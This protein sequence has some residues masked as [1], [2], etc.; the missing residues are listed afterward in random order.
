MAYLHASWSASFHVALAPRTLHTSAIA[1][2]D[3]HVEMSA[4]LNALV[5]G[6]SIGG[7]STAHALL[8]AG[9]GVTVL[10]RAPEVSGN[11]LGAGLGLDEPVCDLLRSWTSKEQFDKN[12]LPLPIEVNRVIENRKAKTLT[13]DDSYKHRATHWSNIHHTLLNALPDKNIIQFH[14]T[15]TDFDQPEGSNKVKVTA[16]V[17]E[18][19][20]PK[21]FEGDFLVACDGSMS[22]V[23]AKFR[24]HD[25]RRY[26][27][28][29]AWRGVMRAGENP[30]VA[31]SVRKAYSMG[32]TLYFDIAKGTHSVLYELPEERL[33]WLWYVNQPEPELKGPSVTIKATEDRIQQMHREAEQIWPPELAQLMKA[34]E[35]PFINA[36]FDKE[37]LDQ[38]VWGRV[39]LLGEA[40]HPTTP[41]G[42]RSTNMAIGDAGKLGS[43]IKKHRGDL[44][45]A[46]QE[47][48]Q[49]RMAQTAKEVLFSRWLGQKKQGLSNPDDPF[50]WPHADK[51]MLD[52]LRQSNMQSF[53]AS[54]HDFATTNDNSTTFPD[55]ASSQVA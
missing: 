12:S 36:I 15:V 29:V 39:A 16:E 26:S 51:A 21:A 9:C 42:L 11:S 53:D 52:Q 17:G 41:H 14:H 22:S 45:A 50:P 35:S 23:R 20:K 33:N 43:A 55:S 32:D 8:R 6:G 31:E 13:H 44:D 7:L 46:L 34:T 24:P 5:I 30:K 19:K 4:K 48:Q 28:Y 49:E 54:K 25:K 47:Y 37:P 38:F 1:T 3:T 27:G 18:D 2:L 40:A 10:E